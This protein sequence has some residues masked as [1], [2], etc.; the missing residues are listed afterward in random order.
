[1]VGEAGTLAASV[2]TVL[3]QAPDVVV[4]DLQFPD[5]SGLQALSSIMKEKPDTT[6]IMLTNH[7]NDLYRRACMNAGASYFFDKSREFGRVAKVIQ[8]LRH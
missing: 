5:G 8:S 6:V 4:L 2:E 3:E 7:A 1:M